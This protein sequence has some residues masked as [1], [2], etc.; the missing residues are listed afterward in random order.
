MNDQLFLRYIEE[1]LVPVLGGHPTLFALDLMGSH[2]TSGVLDKLRSHNIIPSLIPG[3]CTSLIQPLD[4]SIYKPF[5]EILRGLTHTAIFESESV[6]AFD[7]W[8]VG[9]SCILTTSRLG[10]TFYK[11]HL[12]KG[13]I[14][15]KVFRKV[16]LSL[17]VDG[18][19]DH[20]LD[21]KGFSGLEIGD[22]HV[23]YGVVD[24]AGD[25]SINNDDDNAIEF[26]WSFF[27]LFFFFFHFILLYRLLWC[28]IRI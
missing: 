21:I 17:P 26:V 10:D 9:E 8:T 25:I 3:G 11:F 16:G 2:K 28:C 20:E 22:W 14:I 24:E 27:F 5:K 4:V 1:H 15:W 23:D 12:E 6:E 13:D 7:K 19:C 18:S